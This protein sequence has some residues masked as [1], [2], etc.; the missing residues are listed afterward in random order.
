MSLRY[1]TNELIYQVYNAQKRKPAKDDW[2]L[3]VQNDKNECS[4]MMDDNDIQRMKKGRF[5]SIVK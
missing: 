5:K 4:L 1:Q 3:T 2:Y